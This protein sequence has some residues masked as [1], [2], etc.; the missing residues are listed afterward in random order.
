MRWH[1]QPAGGVLY[2]PRGEK[3]FGCRKCHDLTYQS[4]QE[5][6][7]TDPLFGRGSPEAWT[8]KLRAMSKKYEPRARSPSSALTF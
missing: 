8:K 1:V 7:R 4:C 6:H 5:A 2:L 3:Y